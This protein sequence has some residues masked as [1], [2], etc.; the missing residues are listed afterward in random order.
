MIIPELEEIRTHFNSKT[1][2][3]D[4]FAFLCEV[5]IYGEGFSFTMATPKG[6]LRLVTEE[7]LVL[8]NHTFVVNEA[9]MESN[10]KLV[11]DRINDILKECYG[12]KW[13]HVAI[14]INHYMEWDYYDPQ[15]EGGIGD[16]YRNRY[17]N[18]NSS[19]YVESI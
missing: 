4:D 12:E 6:L 9:D 13:S 7:K 2:K 15:G 11:E 8:V 5:Y 1:D 3:I 18:K 10:I 16:F 19:C 14:A 17:M